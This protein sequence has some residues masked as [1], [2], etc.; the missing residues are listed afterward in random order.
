MD[1]GP[2]FAVGRL[3]SAN[4]MVALQRQRNLVETLQQAFASARINFEPML[5]ARRRDNRLP[6]QINADPS[7]PLREP[8]LGGQAIDNLLVDDNG[9]N[10]VLKAVGKENVAETR[11]DD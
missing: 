2:R 9:K 8:D 4:F 1:P 10:S 7:R 6:L 3:E 5:F 11:T